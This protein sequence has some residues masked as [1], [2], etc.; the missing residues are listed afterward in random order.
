MRPVLSNTIR[1]FTEN[2]CWP[3]PGVLQ[4]Q[5][6]ASEL[7][8]V[9]LKPLLELHVGWPRIQGHWARSEAGRDQVPPAHWDGYRW[10]RNLFGIKFSLDHSL[11]FLI[12]DESVKTFAYF[13]NTAGPQ[14]GW[15]PQR[16]RQPV[17]SPSW[18]MLQKPQPS[19]KKKGGGTLVSHSVISKALSSQMARTKT[20]WTPHTVTSMT[21]VRHSG[22]WPKRW[23]A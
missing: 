2:V 10:P 11:K 16:G 20:K 3:C 14:T 17:P 21:R 22:R 18:M 5:S 6:Q 1:S 23:A 13:Q 7:R 12:C 8:R 19:R 4:I 15:G 9:W